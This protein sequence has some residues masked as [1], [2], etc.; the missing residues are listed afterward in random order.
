MSSAGWA[1]ELLV[2]AGAIG[3]L[4]L[5]QL[6]AGSSRRAELAAR[7]HGTA[8]EGSGKSLVRALDV[9]LRRTSS[10]QRLS[11]WLGGAALKLMPVEYI[12]LVAMATLVG[13]LLL[14]PLFV[15][16]LRPGGRPR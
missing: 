4:G 3:M 10:G 11:T 14:A 13:W 15:P 6:L 5:W 12:G 16:W 8:G 2:T 7:G 1:M 9:R